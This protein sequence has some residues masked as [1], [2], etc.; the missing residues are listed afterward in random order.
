[1]QRPGVMQSPPFMQRGAHS[2]EEQE[3]QKQHHWCDSNCLFEYTAHCLLKLVFLLLNVQVTSVK[4]VSKWVKSIAPLVCIWQSVSS[5]TKKMKIKLCSNLVSH[6]SRNCLLCSLIPNWAEQRAH[7]HPLDI[8]SLY[9]W[10]LVLQL[11]PQLC[12]QDCLF[13]SALRGVSNAADSQAGFIM[14]PPFSL[15]I[16]EHKHGYLM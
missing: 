6:V 15:C 12:R 1:M 14:I 8:W 13:R 3:E 16:P 11:K 2:A 10:T 4:H 9:K 7:L 5:G